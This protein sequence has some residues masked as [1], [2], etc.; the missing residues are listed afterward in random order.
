M[1]FVVCAGAS[2]VS[3]CGCIVCNMCNAC[4]QC[5]LCVS[6]VICIVCSVCVVCAKYVCGVQCVC[7]HVCLHV[8]RGSGPKKRYNCWVATSQGERTLLSAPPLRKWHLRS[9]GKEWRE[10][11]DGEEAVSFSI[12]LL[13]VKPSSGRARTPHRVHLVLLLLPRPVVRAPMPLLTS[14]IPESSVCWGREEASETDRLLSDSS[15]QLRKQPSVWW[16][17]TT[18][19]SNTLHCSSSPPLSFSPGKQHPVFPCSYSPE[20]PTHTF[21][22]ESQGS[23]FSDAEAITKAQ[24][25]EVTLPSQPQIQ[26]QNSTLSIKRTFY[27]PPCHCRLGAPVERNCPVHLMGTIAGTK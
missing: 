1:M 21:N 2:R 20:G 12:C 7:L 27:Y 11:M 3:V 14:S 19:K 22:T 23:A 8:L 13:R 25:A 26:D 9:V 10:T 6:V 16:W 4:A 15:G 24:E 5:V 18:K 17:K